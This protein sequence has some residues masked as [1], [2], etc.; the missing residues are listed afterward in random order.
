VYRQI[1]RPVRASIAQILSGIVRYITPLTRIGVAFMPAPAPV[2]N[3]QATV[4]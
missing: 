4:N 2:W 3:V 1:C